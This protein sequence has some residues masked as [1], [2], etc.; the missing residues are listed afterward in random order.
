MRKIS[1]VQYL[2]AQGVLI[3][4]QKLSA[5]QDDLMYWLKDFLQV[6]DE[7]GHCW[8]AASERYSIDDLLAKLDIQ[9]PKFTRS[10]RKKK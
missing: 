6:P 8:D 9:K 3:Q 7:S 4:L 5:Q 2:G 1:I 10:K